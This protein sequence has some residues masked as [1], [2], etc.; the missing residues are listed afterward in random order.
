MVVD[1]VA[2]F[3]MELDD[4]LENVPA[5]YRSFVEA[6]LRQEINDGIF[7]DYQLKTNGVESE[8]KMV[9]KLDNTQGGG[10]MILSQIT[11]MDKEPLYKNIKEDFFIKS[12]SFG[13]T[14]LVKD[15]LIDYKWQI[16]RD[17]ENIAG[18]ETYKASGMM[19]DSIAVT[20]WYTPKIN[21]KD[22]PDR[23]WGLPGF[24][25]KAEF[26]FN[27][28]LITI[29]ANKVSIKEKEIKI[30]RPSKGREMTEEEFMAEMKALQEKYKDMQGGGVDTQ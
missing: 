25:L 1:Y 18:F 26:E 8:Y 2:E 29:T 20:A 24:I 10:G 27:K 22:G 16:S 21:I 14:Y 5:E 28:T 3:K 11:A 17:K 23:I 9:E 6:Q 13:Q 30:T 4:I 19:N 15:Q 12:Y 7:V